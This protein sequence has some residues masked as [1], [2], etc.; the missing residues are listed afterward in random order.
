MRNPGMSRVCPLLGLFLLG[1]SIC[2]ADE[3]AGDA[4]AKKLARVSWDTSR[5]IGS[6][7]PPLPYTSERL[8]ADIEFKRP[9]YVTVL[10]GTNRLLIVEQAG[11]IRS[12]VNE[13]DA[14]ETEVFLKLAD[15]DTYSLC[16]H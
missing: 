13:P 14:K 16:F 9:L 6:P 12:V 3:A 15:H 4:A 8:F 5:V 10:P 1:G 7:E 11:N 2:R